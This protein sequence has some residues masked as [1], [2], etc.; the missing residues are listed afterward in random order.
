M[1]NILNCNKSAL[2]NTF[3]KWSFIYFHIDYAFLHEYD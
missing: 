3:L 2:V 1:V